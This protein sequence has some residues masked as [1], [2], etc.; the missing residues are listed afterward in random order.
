MNSKHKNGLPGKL[1]YRNIEIS[2][3]R[4]RD[5]C[6]VNC[7][8]ILISLCMHALMHQDTQKKGERNVAWKILFL[9]V[10]N[11]VFNS[12][13]ENEGNIFFLWKCIRMLSERISIGIGSRCLNIREIF[14]R[15]SY[16]SI[17]ME[18]YAALSHLDLPFHYPVLLTHLLFLMMKELWA[19]VT[20]VVL[21]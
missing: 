13:D 19:F 15:K 12:L 18:K 17:N 21:W 16:L 10:E 20:I 14:L 2:F 9:H 5:S 11:V 1:K 3:F 8:T 4:I 6:F 7:A